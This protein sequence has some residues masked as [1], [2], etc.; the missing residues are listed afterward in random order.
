MTV[1]PELQP[2]LDALA[3]AEVPAEMYE[4]ETMRAG[5]RGLWSSWNGEPPPLAGRDAVITTAAGDLPIRIYEP[6]APTP[7]PGIV[8]LHGGGFT[9]G[10]LDSHDVTWRHLALRC[11]A[12]VVAI[13]Y[14]LAPEHPFPAAADDALEG[15]RWLSE[16]ADEVGVDTEQLV[17]LGDSAG[18][19]LAAVTALRARDYD[20]PLALQVAI[21]P[22]FDPSR[23]TE[24]YARNG[25]GMLLTDKT[26]RWFWSNYL[27]DETSASRPHVDPRRADL[28]GVAPALIITAEYDPLRD[29]GEDYAH[30]L[31]EAGVHVTYGDYPGMIHGFASMFALTPKS[32]DAID[33]VAEAVNA[34]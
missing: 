16:H 9:V 30:L 21:Y 27:P 31:T 22:C 7:R 19:N 4:P 11:G 1:A 14:R 12:T 13:D 10:D 3:G 15:L 20:L 26:M 17:V 2:L 18:G 33:A 5:F 24:S 23:S 32:F 34:L 28:T 29:E 8:A 6:D 25:K